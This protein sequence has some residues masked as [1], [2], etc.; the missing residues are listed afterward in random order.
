MLVWAAE[1]QSTSTASLGLAMSGS[2]RICSRVGELLAHDQPPEA[3]DL[4]DVPGEITHVPTGT[5]L[6]GRVETGALRG[7]DQLLAV[8]E[9]VFGGL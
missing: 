3:P 1:T 9:E 2:A 6:D 5:R 7:V 4:P 8:T